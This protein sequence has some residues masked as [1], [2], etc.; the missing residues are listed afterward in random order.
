MIN[1][2]WREY[3]LKQQNRD[4]LATAKFNHTKLETYKPYVKRLTAS[5]K[6]RKF[7]KNSDG[8]NHVIINSSHESPISKTINA[9][10]PN[11]LTISVAGSQQGNFAY[12]DRKSVVEVIEDDN[13][14]S[15]AAESETEADLLS[16]IQ[17]AI[18]PEEETES[19]SE[20]EVEEPDT[21]AAESDAKNDEVVDD[22]EDFSDEPFHKHPRFKKVLEERNSYKDSAEK[23]SVMQNYLMDNQLSG[24]EAAKG[25]EIMALMK[26]DPMA[27]LNALKPYVQNLSQ[28]AGIVLP[29]D[30]QTRVDD[31]YLDED[32]GRELAVARA[33]EQ[34]ANAQ[35]NQYAQAQQQNVAR[36]HI[37]SLAE[38]ACLRF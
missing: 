36:Q 34:R 1:Q 23:F 32:A 10:N 25:L 8:H 7:N 2:Q 27:A 18:Q 4:K 21:L 22:A 35:V 29:K 28:A 14:V 9:H 16:V 37:N 33:G 12:Q 5:G 19:H 15:S 38:T 11:N 20:D 26:A 6:I 3:D 24:D 31:G 17:D 30:I 13:A